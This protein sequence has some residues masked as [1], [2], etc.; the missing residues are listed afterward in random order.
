MRWSLLCVLPD[1]CCKLSVVCCALL[2]ELVCYVL[3]VLRC[4]LLFVWCVLL[5]HALLV[6]WYSLIVVVSLLMLRAGVGVAV[7]G[8]GLRLFWL[9]YD[10]KLSGVVCCMCG[11]VLRGVCFGCLVTVVCYSACDVLLLAH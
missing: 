5:A 10:R 6:V 2:F 7:C 11:S 1:V 3:L 9:L 4:V 8:Y